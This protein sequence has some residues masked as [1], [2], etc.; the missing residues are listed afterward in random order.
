MSGVDLA[1]DAI[2]IVRRDRKVEAAPNWATV[3]FQKGHPKQRAGVRTLWTP[4]DP[5]MYGTVTCH[6][7]SVAAYFIVAPGTTM[8]MTIFS[9]RLEPPYI[10]GYYWS[11]VSREDVEK[12]RVLL[13]LLFIQEA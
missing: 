1:G 11:M 9:L 8:S 5:P 6:L 3:Y 12:S 7:H 10:Q 13:E 2:S 4:L